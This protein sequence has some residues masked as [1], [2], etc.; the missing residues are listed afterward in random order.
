MQMSCV[1]CKYLSLDTFHTFYVKNEDLQIKAV[2][3]VFVYIDS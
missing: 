1:H 3:L 2:F